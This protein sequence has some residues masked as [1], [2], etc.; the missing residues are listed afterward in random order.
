MFLILIFIVNSIYKNRIDHFGIFKGSGGVW[1]R[2][3]L[4]LRVGKFAPDSGYFLQYFRAFK[5]NVDG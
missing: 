2:S 4:T 1:A 5:V 3:H